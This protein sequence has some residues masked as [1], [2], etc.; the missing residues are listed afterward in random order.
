MEGRC[1]LSCQVVTITE[2]L[3]LICFGSLL[4][5]GYFLSAMT[6]YEKNG[7]RP[8]LSYQSFLKL[9]GQPSWASSPLSTT[10]SWLPPVGDV[11]TC[12]ISN[13]PTVK[14]LGYEEIGQ[15]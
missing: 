8:P 12:E 2:S 9:A 6:I 4:T 15:V 11:G 5:Q 7:A 13:V 3:C 1:L 14:E 10:L